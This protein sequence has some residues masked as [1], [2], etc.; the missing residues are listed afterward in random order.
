MKPGDLVTP[1]DFGAVDIYNDS[2]Q[3]QLNGRPAATLAKL[4]VG[5]IALVVSVLGNFA[6]IMGN[7]AVGYVM[8]AQLE[9][10]HES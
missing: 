2:P 5:E 3:P 8:I 4:K 9:V 10:I 7:Y 6:I 1:G